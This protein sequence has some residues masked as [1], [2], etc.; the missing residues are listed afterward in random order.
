MRRTRLA[1]ILL[2]VGLGAAAGYALGRRR[3]NSAASCPPNAQ[4][5]P[6]HPDLGS[7]AVPAPPLDADRLASAK[8]ADCPYLSARAR[9]DEGAAAK[10]LIKEHAK[11]PLAQWLDRIDHD[12]VKGGSHAPASNK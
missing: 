11:L 7:A 2:L 8:A 12:K 1:L 9:Q 10:S 6:G 4:L 5:P 3:S